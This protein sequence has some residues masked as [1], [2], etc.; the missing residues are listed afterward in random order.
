LPETNKVLIYPKLQR[1]ASKQ[2]QMDPEEIDGIASHYTAQ[3]YG[4]L[5]N[6][7]VVDEKD[8]MKFMVIKEFINSIILNN[9]NSYHPF[10]EI[11]DEILSAD[12]MSVEPDFQTEPILHPD[13]ETP[14]PTKPKKP[15]RKKKDPPANKE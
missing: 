11:I 2:E 5:R 15:G 13:V 10:S 3:L 1:Y 8:I 12:T 7:N 4:S 9:H 14:P 6:Q